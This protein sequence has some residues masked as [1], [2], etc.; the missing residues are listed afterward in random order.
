[1]AIPIGG[2]ATGFDTETL[3]QR[4][5][6]VE[7]R[8]I[9]A[10]ETRKL[11]FEALSAAFKDL[12]T[13]LATLKTRAGALKDPENFFARS[14]TSSDET[15]ATATAASGSVRG[16]F[17]VT[18]TQLARGS[19]AA[20]GVTV[21]A[22][23]DTIASVD[24]N[25]TFKLGAS[26]TEVNVPVTGTTTLEQ[27]VADINEANAGVRAAAVNLGTAEAPDYQLTM[28]SNSTGATNN[29]VIVNDPTNL[30]IANTQTAL[31]ATFSVTGIGAFT[32]S[33][34][35]FSDVIE[36][37][38]ITL[39]AGA[40]STD[41][42]ITYDKSGTQSKVQTLLDAYNDVVSTIDGQTKAVTRPDGSVS[43][44][45]FTGDAVPRVL[46][47]GLASTIAST[48]SGTFTRLAEIGVTTQKDGTLTL[49]GTKFQ[50]AFN[51]DASAVGALIAGTTDSDGIADLVEAKADTAT[52]A[53]TGTIA[54]RQDGLTASIKAIQK[55]IDQAVVRLEGTER[56]MRA[57]FNNLETLV[58]RVQR[59]GG[60]LLAQLAQLP[61]M[62]SSSS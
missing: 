49:D 53:I 57:R 50:K 35:T 43:L 46:R 36:G 26:G 3:I 31:D 21:D 4:L 29:I 25:F 55:Q 62:R 52:K 19:I 15:V 22:L 42:A 61:G 9:T 14:V 12:N 41:L 10:L 18:P 17:T 27:L 60:S 5:L 45:A 13:K 32:R 58:A 34:N 51:D 59:T 40:G 8:P 28:T 7:R 11:K 48:V 37:V 1:M 16:T 33:S 39:K 24:A 23:T 6:A 44:G 2:L 30:A 54:V 47:M 20:A 38:T 56:T